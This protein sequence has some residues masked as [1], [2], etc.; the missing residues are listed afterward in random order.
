[1]PRRS[2]CARRSDA[3]VLRV[4]DTVDVIT[5]EV[6]NAKCGVFAGELLDLF[7]DQ[8]SVVDGNERLVDHSA[9]QGEHGRH[10]RMSKPIFNQG[11]HG[12]CDSGVDAISRRWSRYLVYNRE[13]RV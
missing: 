3:A 8:D 6:R 9:C 4:R 11:K 12:L 2:A 7:E 1:M 10:K 5:G 13:R